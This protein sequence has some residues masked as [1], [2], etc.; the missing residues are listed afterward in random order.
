MTDDF[1]YNPVS[2]SVSVYDL[3]ATLLNQLGIDHKK[4]TC[5]FQGRHFRLM[6]V[7]GEVVQKVLA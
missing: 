4:Q 3:Q 5:K 6:D 2:D 1:S 7:H